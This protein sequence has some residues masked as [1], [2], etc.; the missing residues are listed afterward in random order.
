[1]QTIALPDLHSAY[2]LLNLAQR[3]KRFYLGRSMF[4]GLS[5]WDGDTRR[6]N[7]SQ[8]VRELLS[9]MMEPMSIGEI[10]ARIED[11]TG[12]KI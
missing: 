4:L 11:L 7:I 5:V 12:L 6:L 8:A 1:M 2:A 3:D 10:N 9:T